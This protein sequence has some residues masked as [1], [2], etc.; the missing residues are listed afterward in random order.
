M[1]IIAGKASSRKI[2]SRKV[3]SRKV[4]SRKVRKGNSYLFNT[5]VNVSAQR[6]AASAEG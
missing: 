5:F 4:S 3:S 1:P 2:S 6:Q